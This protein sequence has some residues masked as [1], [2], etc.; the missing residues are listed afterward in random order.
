MAGYLMNNQYD[1]LNKSL[2]KKRIKE[3]LKKW[4]SKFKMDYEGKMN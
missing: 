1:Q 4:F 2:V 3:S